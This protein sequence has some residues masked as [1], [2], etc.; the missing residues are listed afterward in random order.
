MCQFVKY[1]L[2]P[3]SNLRMHR[4]WRLLCELTQEM[5]TTQD[6]VQMNSRVDC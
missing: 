4:S 3:V 6:V 2:G 1:F 5:T